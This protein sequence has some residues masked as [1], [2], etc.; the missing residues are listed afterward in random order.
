MLDFHAALFLVNPSCV[1]VCVFVE[2]NQTLPAS[3][4]IVNYI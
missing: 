4:E 1:C 3:D 2:E